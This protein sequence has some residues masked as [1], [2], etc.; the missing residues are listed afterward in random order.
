MRTRTLFSIVALATMSGRAQAQDGRAA[1][2]SA[3][4]SA[5]S[6][7]SRTEASFSGAFA[8]RFSRVVGL[9]IEATVVPRLRSPYPGDD[10]ASILASP[11]VSAVFPLI[12]P[13]PR[14]ENAGG[15]MVILSN[16]VR[17]VVP[18][19]SARLEPYFVAGGG[20]ASVRHTADF[21]F[22]TYQPGVLSSITALLGAAAVP[23]S[24][25]S[26]AFSYP[27]TTSSVDM[28]LTIGGG[29][30]MRVAQQMTIDAD[31]RMFRLLGQKDRSVGRFGV[32]VRYRF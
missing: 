23:A 7:D 24:L 14:F 31:L 21:V 9:E 32:G 19:T 29:L 13:G 28:A 30:S 17:L 8:Y 16:N 18:T 2:V 15:R 3:S 20:I 10:Y 4:V 5:M 26:S 25:L 12:Y 6:V 27:I 11:G 22:P 1:E